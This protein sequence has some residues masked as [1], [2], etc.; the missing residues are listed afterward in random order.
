MVWLNYHHLYYFYVI[1]RE[2][3]IAKASKHLR[4]SPSSLSIQLRQLEE[5]FE[6]RLFDRSKQNLILTGT[7]RLVFEYAAEIFRLGAEMMEAVKGRKEAGPLR[8]NLGILDSIPKAIAHE[9]VVAAY[10][11]DEC[12]VSVVEAGSE[13]LLNSLRGHALHLTLTNSHAPM[14][15]KADLFSRCVADLPVAVFGAPQFA[16]L[17]DNFPQSLNAQPFILP[18]LDS[19]LR[20]DIEHYFERSNLTPRIIGESQESELDKRLASS[21]HALIAM[22]SYGIEP[23]VEAGKLIEIGVLETLREQIWLTGVKA[24]VI[25]PIAAQLLETFALAAPS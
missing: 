19:K 25:N 3:S 14:T 9:F 2:G 4:L 18:T 22:S 15:S 5:I 6:Q 11:I 13:E 21:G 12:F 17:R 20:N 7:G 23:E 8:L 10:T 24:H 1:A 16:F